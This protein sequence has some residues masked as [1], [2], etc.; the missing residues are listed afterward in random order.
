MCE[1]WMSLVLRGRVV[2]MA[3]G[4]FLVLCRE[5]DFH[6]GI[7]SKDTVSL[8]DAE[9]ALV[10]EAKLSGGGAAGM[11]FSRETDGVRGIFGA[12]NPC[13]INL[14]CFFSFIIFFHHSVSC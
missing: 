5:R 2:L 9:G 3:P 12:L 14:C 10:D 4:E 13:R 11:S 1:Y 7:G 6:F 8:W